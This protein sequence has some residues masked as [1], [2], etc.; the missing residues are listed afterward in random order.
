MSFYK[1]SCLLSLAFASPCISFAQSPNEKDASTSK[2]GELTFF[3]DENAFYND[4]SLSFA[5]ETYKSEYTSGST[6]IKSYNGKEE[7]NS[8]LIT[9]FLSYSFKKNHAL[10]LELSY[11]SENYKY[12]YDKTYYDFPL[13]E[14]ESNLTAKKNGFYNPRFS[15]KFRIIEQIKNDKPINLDLLAKFS[16]NLLPAKNATY[17]INDSKNGTVASGNTAVIV[18]ASISQKIGSFNWLVNANLKYVGE[19]KKTETYNDSNSTSDPFIE[20][21]I[22]SNGQYYF[23]S[24]IG[25]DFGIS[26]HLI[27]EITAKNDRIFGKIVSE[28]RNETKVS[29]GLN[30]NVIENKLNIYSE[31][32]AYAGNAYNQNYYN[33]NYTVKETQGREFIFGAKF[34]F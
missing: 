5:K 10:G 4:V 29:L 30:L 20:F 21:L 24:I 32:N 2:L 1:K 13:N 12:S 3:Q 15:Y 19:T 34:T 6:Y 7:K 14:N 26:Y 31:I 16:P 23:N 18:G 11:G 22:A 8:I 33:T 9:E 17:A 27:P 28:P 25:L